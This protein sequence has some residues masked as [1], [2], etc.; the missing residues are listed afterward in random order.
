MNER[1]QGSLEYLLLIGGAILVA[2][3]IIGLVISTSGTVGDEAQAQALCGAK[4]TYSLC[5]AKDGCTEPEPPALPAFDATEA[6]TLD[7]GAIV[8]CEPLNS[9]GGTATS[10]TNFQTCGFSDD[11]LCTPPAT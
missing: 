11:P 8:Y 9:T 7:S 10:Q 3:I 1:G 2:V 5:A 6:I 4:G